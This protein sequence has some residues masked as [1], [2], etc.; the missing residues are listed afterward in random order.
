[1]LK[2]RFGGFGLKSWPWA[3]QTEQPTIERTAA[4]LPGGEYAAQL[5]VGRRQTLDQALTAAR[6]ILHGGQ[7]ATR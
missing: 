3:A 1:M 2:N 4:L 5:A 7:L 6:P